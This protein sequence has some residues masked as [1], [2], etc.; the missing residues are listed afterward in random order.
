MFVYKIFRASFEELNNKLF[1]KTLKPLEQILNDSN[2][3]K[4]ENWRVNTLPKIRQ[5]VKDFFNGK[6]P[7]RGINPDEA[8]TTGAIQACIIK[9]VFAFDVTSL[10]LGIETVGEIFTKIIEKNTNFPHQ[11]N[12]ANVRIKIYQG[13]RAMT[14]DNI[15]LG[16]FLLSDTKTIEGCATN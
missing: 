11:D 10:S 3:K 8:V 7:N 5:L 12:P 6:E 9:D 1:R 15:K 13:E 14:K 16:D 4:I 2:P